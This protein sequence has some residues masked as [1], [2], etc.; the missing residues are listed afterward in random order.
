M[1]IQ[2]STITLVCA[3]VLALF[4]SNLLANNAENVSGIYCP[5]DVWVKCGDDVSNLNVYGYAT[6]ETY[7]GTTPVYATETKY[8]LNDCGVGTIQRQFGAYDPYGEYHSCIQTIWIEPSSKPIFINWPKDMTLAGCDAD[9]HPNY[10]EEDGWPKV[11]AYGCSNLGTS[12]EDQEFDFGPGCSKVIRTWRIIDWCVYDP[13]YSQTRG[14]YTHS[15]IIKISNVKEPDVTFPNDIYVTAYNCDDAYVDLPDVYIDY[16]ACGGMVTVTHNSSFAD[17]Y[18]SSRASGTY[19]VGT[20][21][22]RYTV[23]YGCGL[24]IN[25]YVDVTVDNQLRPDAYCITSLAV[26]LMPVYEADDNYPSDGMI[27]IWA[28]D[29]DINSTSPC[30]HGPLTFS[31]SQDPDDNVKTFTC[32]EL[33]VNELEMWVTDINGKQNYCSVTVDVQ[34]NGA[35]IANC[36]EGTETYAK[37]DVE[38]EITMYH[39]GNGIFD[40]EMQLTGIDMEELVT[41]V[42]D[43]QYVENEM[44]VT[45]NIETTYADTYEMV[46]SAKTGTYKIEGLAQH[47]HYMLVPYKKNPVNKRTTKFDLE[48]LAKHLSGEEVVSDPYFLLAA[49]VDDS[50]HVDDTDLEILKEYEKGERRSLPTASMWSFIDA[51]YSFINPESPWDE[52]LVSQNEMDDMVGTSSYSVDFIGILKGHFTNLSDNINTDGR[53]ED[54]IIARVQVYP[55]P[56]VDVINLDLEALETSVGQIS[57]V[58]MAGRVVLAQAIQINEGTQ[59]IS[60]P[61]KDLLAGTYLYEV[62]VNGKVTSGK[63]VK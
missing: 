32:A 46:T 59:T 1:K 17:Q 18:G 41:E 21:T 30:D 3:F 23:T 40:V 33:G 28:S 2:Q 57:I 4:S 42:L 49:D 44:I 29:L 13:N 48:K 25:H 8:N 16:A 39:D 58:D 36:G 34:N 27:E 54:P 56:F 6:L 26:A 43:T 15:Q 63:L 62:V 53:S 22:V 47:G 51:N 52:P 24:E 61:A 5:P 14:I 19:P 31:F 12:Y 9:V 55:N 20:T 45:T 11:T 7:T 50:R 60:I 38:G 37:F 35:Q 10:L